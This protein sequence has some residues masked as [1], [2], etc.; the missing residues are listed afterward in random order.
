MARILVLVIVLASTTAQADT[1]CWE[2]PF[3]EGALVAGYRVEIAG[4][5]VPV[6][7]VSEDGGLTWCAEV[8]STGTY[9]MR[10]WALWAGDPIEAENSPKT[11]YRSLACRA[12][13]NENESVDLVD[14]STVLGLLGGVC[15]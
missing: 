14:V 10:L 9:E 2:Q 12:D 4:M 1:R 7:P 13:L 5:E 8:P 15:E 6:V 11:Y 3:V